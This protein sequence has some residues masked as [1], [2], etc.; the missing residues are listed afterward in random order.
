ME[1]KP[2]ESRPSGPGLPR[3]SLDEA[4]GGGEKWGRRA[5]IAK[6]QAGSPDGG[7]RHRRRLRQWR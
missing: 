2:I 4:F 6:G 3:L 1:A 5:Y 7:L